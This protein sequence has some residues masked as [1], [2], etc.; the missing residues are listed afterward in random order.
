M[1]STNAHYCRCQIVFGTGI[2][3]GGLQDVAHNHSW[4]AG[5]GAGIKCAGGPKP[6]EAFGLRRG[7]TDGTMGKVLAASHGPPTPRDPWWLFEVGAILYT[8]GES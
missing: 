1:A 7:L 5:Q 8:R 4:D 2:F 6:G 3:A